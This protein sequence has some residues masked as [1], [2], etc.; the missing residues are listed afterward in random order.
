MGKHRFDKPVVILNPKAGSGK[1]LGTWPRLEPLFEARLGPVQVLHTEAPNHAI[2]LTRNAIADGA[3]LVTAVGGDGTL[4]EVVNGLL[5][6]GKAI[7]ERTSLALFP[8]GTGGDFK[9][10]ALFPDN[11]EDVIAAIAENEI[12]RIDGCVA[13]FRAFDGTRRERHFVNAAGFGI[14]GEVAVAAKQNFLTR[15][16]GTGAFW[17]AT[18]VA[19]LSYRA[20]R[21]RLKFDD[22][23][24]LEASVMEVALGNGRYEGGGLLLCPNAALDSG[25]VDV[26]VIHEAGF[27]EFIAAM[28]YLYSGKV[29][30]HPKCHPYRAQR[31]V[32]ESD[33][34]VA[35]QLDGEALGILPLEVEVLPA[36]IPFAGI[37]APD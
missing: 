1:T 29:Y 31:V 13:R 22:S 25:V 37:G 28:P 23:P 5:S 20:K 14:G 16:S 3:D 7:S 4:S 21:V 6:N 24:T 32:A 15:Y 9:R 12:R 30:S 27:F 35:I 10:S 19:F 11:A 17:W 36:A 2:E 26:T 33:E 18:A 34:E 8:L